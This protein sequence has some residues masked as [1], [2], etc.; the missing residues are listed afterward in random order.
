MTVMTRA[1]H[2]HCRLSC[3]AHA[4]MSRL[5]VVL[6]PCSPLG[7]VY[8][9]RSTSTEILFNIVCGASVTTCGTIHIK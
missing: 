2:C 4:E 1:I 6:E 5:P 9:R 8:H 7:G 3:S